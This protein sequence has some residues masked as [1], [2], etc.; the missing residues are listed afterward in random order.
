M[1]CSNPNGKAL[2]G[3][4]ASA[5][6]CVQALV[7]L[8]ANTALPDQEH[9]APAVP[10]ESTCEAELAAEEAAEPQHEEMLKPTS[11]LLDPK[12]QP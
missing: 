1:H 6:T 5:E 2:A 10:E 4:A 9:S 7:L 11:A 12:V 3:S 8:A